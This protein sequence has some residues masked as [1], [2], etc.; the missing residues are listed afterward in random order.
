M[1]RGSPCHRQT[2]RAG[3]A[4]LEEASE[5]VAALCGGGWFEQYW[6][7]GRSQLCGLAAALVLDRAEIPSDDRSPVFLVGTGRCGSTIVYSCMAMHPAF[8]WIPSWL[9]EAPGFPILAAGNRLWDLW[10]MDRFRETRF[11]PKPVEP[12]PVF[13]HWT[14][15]FRRE[16]IPEEVINESRATIPPLVS[17]LQRWHGNPRFLTKMVGRPVK[18]E[19]LASLFP[20]ARFV[21]I[22]RA[23][24]PTTSSLLLVEFYRGGGFE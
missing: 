2:N 1:G 10:G 5:G 11:F 7:L 22:T 19:L 23:L 14:K 16:D 13:E 4:Q 12:N 8:S 9:T 24:K 3:N 21:H 17:R 18:I 6:P 15:S 20:G